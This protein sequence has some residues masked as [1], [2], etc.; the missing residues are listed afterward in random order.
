MEFIKA[1]NED[2]ASKGNETNRKKKIEAEDKR[3]IRIK[4]LRMKVSASRFTQ[5]YS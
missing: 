4:K 5:Y 3:I 1:V 2:E